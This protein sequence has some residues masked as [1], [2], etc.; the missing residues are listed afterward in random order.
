MTLLLSFISS[1]NVIHVSDR[2]TTQSFSGSRVKDF[3]NKFNKSLI[4]ALNDC[5]CF[6]SLTGDAFI[7]GIHTDVFLAAA[8]CGVDP[9]DFFSIE[10]IDVNLVIDVPDFDTAVN[11]I[12]E[13]IHKC[14]DAES[15][16]KSHYEFV[17]CGY[18]K[19]RKRNGDMKPF[20]F[21][22][23]KSKGSM[24][25]VCTQPNGED[26]YWFDDPRRCFLVAN[27]DGYYKYKARDL[28]LS[29]IKNLPAVAAKNK[30]VKAVREMSSIHPTV[31][32]DVLAMHFD[33]SV[34]VCIKVLY[35]PFGSSC[36]K[37]LAIYTP[38][39]IAKG[40]LFPPTVIEPDSADLRVELDI[41]FMRVVFERDFSASNQN[42]RKIGYISIGPQ[43]RK[44][45]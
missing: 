16:R 6:L 35:C 37:E 40:H 2:L 43:K 9:S 3:D 31:G 25:F 45:L 17:F 13:V 7:S 34:D 18:K 30:L 26:K 23:K 39:L 4:L 14:V 27:P 41:G 19:H 38:W 21:C 29:Q 33:L 11:R 36:D 24:T 1:G 12:N 8:I 22:M 28:L 32:S 20:Y 42:L 15:I 44:N 10:N 5:A